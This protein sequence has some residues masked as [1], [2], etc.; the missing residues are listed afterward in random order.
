MD[1]EY[2]TAEIRVNDEWVPVEFRDI[3]AGQIFRLTEPDGEI[4]TD[5]LGEYAFDCIADAYLNEDGIFTVEINS[6]R[7]EKHLNE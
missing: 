2:R 4:V 3:K 7:L 6:D 5:S 1:Y